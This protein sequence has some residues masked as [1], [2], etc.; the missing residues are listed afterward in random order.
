MNTHIFF[1]IE[2]QLL[3]IIAKLNLNILFISLVQIFYLKYVY[4]LP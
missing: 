1:Q 4:I 3:L 2:S